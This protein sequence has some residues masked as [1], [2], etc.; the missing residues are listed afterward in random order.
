MALEGHAGME[1]HSIAKCY[2]NSIHQILTKK[3][4][5]PLLYS[6]QEWNEE[7]K[8]GRILASLLS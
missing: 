5:V 3:E 2:P 4:D 8:E 6:A 1:D 7:D